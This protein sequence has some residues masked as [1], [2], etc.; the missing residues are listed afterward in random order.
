MF[1]IGL[2]YCYVGTPQFSV[3]FHC[4]QIRHN[5]KNEITMQCHL[6]EVAGPPCSKEEFCRKFW[7]K[8]V[9]FYI[10]FNILDNSPSCQNSKVSYKST[11]RKY[12]CYYINEL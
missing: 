10:Y 2:Q 8:G 4:K 1:R 5:F 12:L 7:P 11:A 6:L 3:F 9:T